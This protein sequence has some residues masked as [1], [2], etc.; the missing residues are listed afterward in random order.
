[1]DTAAAC[2]A[3]GHALDLGD[4]HVVVTDL[5]WDTYA[6]SFTAPRPSHLLDELPAARRALDTTRQDSASATADASS[7]HTHL[8]N[9]PD[10]ERAGAVLEIVR[11]HVAG[12]LGYPAADAVE[13]ERPFTDLGIDSLSAVELRNGM[14]RITGL[15]LPSTLV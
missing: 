6:P 13:P 15:R 8:A 7:L 12:V 5:R 11:G 1:M 10:Y 3:L 9:L 4:T 2:E 14:N